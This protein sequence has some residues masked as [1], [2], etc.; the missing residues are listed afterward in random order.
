MSRKFNKML[1]KYI[2]KKDYIKIRRKTAEGWD[3]IGGFILQ[4]SKKFLLI[5]KNEEFSLNG[6]II[7]PQIKYSI[8]C[9]DFEKAFKK[10]LFNEGITERDYGINE[11]ITLDSFQS[12]FQD[13]QDNDYHV[14]VECE[15][16]SNP[17]FTIGPI[18]KVSKKS[19]RIR[20]YDATGKLNQKPSKILYKDI[21]KITFGDRYSTIFRKY[22]KAKYY[23]N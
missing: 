13:L 8:R 22:L 11:Q 3:Y 1:N 5:Q 12:I 17:S 16:L 18:T 4:L 21:T 9:C 2:E 10:I 19:V 7:I 14:I 6:Y 20:Y 23:K 15:N